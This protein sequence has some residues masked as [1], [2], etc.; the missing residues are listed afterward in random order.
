MDEVANGTDVENPCDNQTA[1]PDTTNEIWRDA[2]CDGD[3]EL[4]GTEAD[5][6]I[7][8]GCSDQADS[9]FCIYYDDTENCATLSVGGIDIQNEISLYPNPTVDVINIDTTKNLERVELYSIT[10]QL[11]IK[12]S[13]SSNNNSISLGNMPSGVYLISILV[14]DGSRKTKKIIKQ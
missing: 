2:D 10:G 9:S 12:M 4:N 11:L 6:V 14:K 8:S 1:V 5:C 3:G 13:V 7:A